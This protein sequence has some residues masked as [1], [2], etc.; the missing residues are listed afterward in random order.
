M[1]ISRF[2]FSQLISFIKP[3]KDAS[4]EKLNHF[5]QQLND[6]ETN[7]KELNGKEETLKTKITEIK[8]QI[9]GIA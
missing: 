4:S 2:S 5:I 8:K 3:I 6:I 7:I 9:K 1:D